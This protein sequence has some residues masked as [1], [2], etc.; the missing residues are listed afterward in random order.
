MLSERKS[1]LSFT[2]AACWQGPQPPTAPRCPVP[3]SSTA[4]YG[5]SLA[6]RP[7][8]HAPI[9]LLH[10]AA[11]AVGQCQGEEFGRAC[12]GARECCRL[13]PWL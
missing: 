1:C 13:P 11:A 7:T 9:H 2:R 10:V 12:R 5:K 6:N 8:F 4:P 3:S